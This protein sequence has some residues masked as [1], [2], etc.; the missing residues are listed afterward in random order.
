MDYPNFGEWK[1]SPFAV[2]FIGS[3]GALLF[4]PK[5]SLWRTL[6]LLFTG[7]VS[8]GFLA[9]WLMELLSFD[10]PNALAA[11]AFLIGT[12]GQRLVGGLLKIG[13]HFLVNPLGFIRRLRKKS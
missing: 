2:G 1:S 5:F 4:E 7:S 8:A 13:E 9:P 3:L 10:S 6:L 11:M 12:L